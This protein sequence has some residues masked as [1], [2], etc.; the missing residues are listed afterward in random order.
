MKKS[1]ALLC[2]IASLSA[3]AGGMGD[4]DLAQKN[5]TYALIGGGYYGSN[6][7][8]NYTGYLFDDLFEKK[9]FN[10]TNNSGY[11]QIGLG[12][13]AHIGSLEFD[14]QLVLSKLGES[15]KF[16]TGSSNWRFSQNIDF[17]Y[18]WM[19]KVN[20]LDKLTGYG[21]LGVHYAR[22]T[23]QKTTSSQTATRFNNYKDQVGFNLGAG[24]FYAIYHHFDLGVKYQHW[25]YGSAQVSGMNLISSLIDVQDIKPAFNLIGAELRYTF[26]A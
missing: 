26:S 22:F 17:G 1:F 20:L 8:A 12:A 14:H 2:S 3:F 9:S 18:D 21:I 11:G 15:V 4:V 24:L 6:F 25:Q 13:T 5:T 19:P 7:Q 16:Q 10:D 23:Y